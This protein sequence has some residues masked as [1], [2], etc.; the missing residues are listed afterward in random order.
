LLL[1]KPHLRGHRGESR[2]L[3]LNALEDTQRSKPAPPALRATLGPEGPPGQRLNL[4]Y[5][6]NATGLLPA[7]FPPLG[8]TG[9]EN[10]RVLDPAEKQ[11]EAFVALCQQESPSDSADFEGNPCAAQTKPNPNHLSLNSSALNRAVHSRQCG[12]VERM[13]GKQ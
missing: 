6:T 11:W 2:G 8:G 5:L 3:R 9:N 12:T 13:H 10:R 1:C 7:N 4:L